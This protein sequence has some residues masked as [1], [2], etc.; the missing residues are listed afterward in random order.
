MGFGMGWTGIVVM[1]LFGGG[2]IF[3]GMWLF[4]NINLNNHNSISSQ[5]SALDLLDQ[6]Y[7]KGEITKEEYLQIK[8]DI[9]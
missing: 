2:I 1:V 4:K 6:R 5:T 7:A 9:L 3:G 8:K